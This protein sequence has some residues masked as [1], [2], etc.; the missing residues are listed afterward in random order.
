MSCGSRSRSS[1]PS[2]QGRSDSFTPSED[3]STTVRCREGSVGGWY[4]Q[5][6]PLRTQVLFRRAAL[7]LVRFRFGRLL[8][9]LRRVT[10][11]HRLA[12][13]RF[14]QPGGDRNPVCLGGALGELQSTAVQRECDLTGCHTFYRTTAAAVE[15]FSRTTSQRRGTS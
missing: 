14:R 3:S 6:S 1:V 5:T 2:S 13:G 10:G 15:R 12:P 9:P 4:V 11:A 7:G 8:R